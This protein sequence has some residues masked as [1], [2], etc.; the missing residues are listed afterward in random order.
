MRPVEVKVKDIMSACEAT[1]NAG[2]RDGVRLAG[3]ILKGCAASITA[4]ENAQIIGFS[5]MIA[6][7]LHEMA[8]EIHAKLEEKDREP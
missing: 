7:A 1:Y 2:V 8:D 4:Q 5:K 3:D 6:K